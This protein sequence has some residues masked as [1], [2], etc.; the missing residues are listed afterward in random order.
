MLLVGLPLCPSGFS[1]DPA[2]P[3][4]EGCWALVLWVFLCC[5]RLWCGR[6][7]RF[8][9]L[10]A[11]VGLVLVAA[12][13]V[14]VVCTRGPVCGVLV[15][16]LV[17][18]SSPLWAWFGGSV[19]VQ[20]LCVVAPLPPW[21]W[22][23]GVDPRHPWLGS[24]GGGVFPRRPLCVPSPL[25]LFAASLGGLFPWCLAGPTRAVVGVRW[26][27]VGSGGV[28]DA[29]SGPFPWCFPLG[30][31]MLA[32]PVRVY[33]C[34]TGSPFVP[35]RY[36][37]TCSV[38]RYSSRSSHRGRVHCGSQGSA[39]GT[40]V[41]LAC[42]DGRCAL[43]AAPRWARTAVRAVGSALGQA[44]WSPPQAGA[45]AGRCPT[46][47]GVSHLIAVG[48]ILSPGGPQTPEVGSLACV[49]CGPLSSRP[50]LSLCGL[51]WWVFC[52]SLVGW[53]AGGGGGGSS[54]LLAVLLVC[55]SPPLL[56]EACRRWRRVVSR[57]SW[58]KALGVAPRHSWLG[59][60]GVGEGVGL[61]HSWL[62]APGLWS[63]VPRFLLRV[64]GWWS[65]ATPGWGVRWC[66]W[67]VAP[68]HAWL[69]FLGADSRHSWLGSAGCGEAVSAGLGEGFPV[70]CVFV[71]RCVVVCALCVCGGGVG[72]SVSS[73]CVGAC[74][75]CGSWFPWLGLAAGVGVAVASVCCWWS[76]ATP[77][78]GS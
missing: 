6:C 29:G 5:V 72:V 35:A 64:L 12:V 65:P 11:F 77:G 54:P 26:G 75:A 47:L 32:L 63:V 14:C 15:V 45:T 23:P 18:L 61:R 36:K 7:S 9:V 74:V 62:R 10:C 43:P 8:G 3:L 46:V 55:V 70:L 67:W 37:W 57:H 59:S 13:A 52:L 25:F 44:H 41:S 71:A 33:F 38:A 40:C 21:L 24:V 66:W 78:E 34:C 17:V 56:A 22:G 76:L 69:R 16:R 49:S 2:A 50:L 58:L 48:P 53:A 68:P 42:P 51:W 19:W 28:L 4:T 31:P 27:W 60:S 73:V 20:G 1:G 39:C 30:G